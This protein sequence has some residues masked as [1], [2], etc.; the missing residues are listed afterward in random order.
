VNDDHTAITGE[1]DVHLEALRSRREC[2]PERLQRVFGRMRR[3]ATMPDDGPAIRIEK[4][5]HANSCPLPAINR[6]PCAARQLMAD[7]RRPVAA[8]Q[9]AYCKR[10]ISIRPIS[11]V[12]MNVMRLLFVMF[13]PVID[14]VTFWP[15]TGS[16]QLKFAS[17]NAL[18]GTSPT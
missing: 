16:R 2:L 18:T 14:Q 3:V 12:P 9:N 17:R 7:G 13:V 5:V 15:G 6:R 1:M 10:V 4:R 11:G 8:V